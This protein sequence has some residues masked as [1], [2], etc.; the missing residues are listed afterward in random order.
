VV[1]VSGWNY[2]A[3]GTAISLVGGNFVNNDIYEFSYTAKDPTVNGIGFAAV[4]DFVTWLRY[5]AKDDSGTANPMAGDI[6]AHLHDH[7]SQP[8][9]MLNDFRTLGFNASEAT[10]RC[11]TRSSTGSARR[12]H[13]HELPLLE[14]GTTQRNRQDQLYPERS[15]RSPTRARPITSAASRRA[16][17]QVHADQY[18]PVRDGGVLVERILGEGRLAVPHQHAGHGDLPGIRSRACTSS[19]AISTRIR[20][21]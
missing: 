21:T 12:R 2:N 1:A 10:A 15:S 6:N 7:R 9:R 16:L 11:S 17:R 20:A 19:R 13:Q 8:A 3:D 14:P 18:V 4:R 5:E